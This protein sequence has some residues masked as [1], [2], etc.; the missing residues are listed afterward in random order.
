L[1]G[2]ETILVVAIFINLVGALDTLAVLVLIAGRWI[3]PTLR[4]RAVL[5][6]AGAGLR[7][8]WSLAGPVFLSPATDTTARLILA[9]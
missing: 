1:T 5:S 4:A 2:G 9:A 8:S 3:L 7:L 6:V